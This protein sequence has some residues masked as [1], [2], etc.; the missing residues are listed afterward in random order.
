MANQGEEMA[1]LGRVSSLYRYPVKSMAGESVASIEVGWQGMSGDRRWAFVRGGME[2]NGFPWLTAR[3]QPL[4]TQYRPRLVSPDDPDT[5]L[6]LVTNPSGIEYDV[7]DPALAVEL[8]HNS[9]VIRQSRGI[10]DTFPV[11][12]ISTAT[13]DAIGSSVGQ[14]LDARRFRPNIV[15]DLSAPTAFAED[16]LVGREILLGSI[17]LR[18]DKRDK[19]CVMINVDPDTS[20]KNPTVLRAVAQERQ[21]CLGV[22]ATVV[23]TGAIS[24]GDSV[25]LAR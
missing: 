1:V 20:T 11:S 6:T 24:V 4:M 14:A 23:Q 3:E 21:A 17:V 16:G 25:S 15:M 22:Y 7:A 5:S 13:I 9:H 8:G 2:R 18:V 12:L 10:F 19:R